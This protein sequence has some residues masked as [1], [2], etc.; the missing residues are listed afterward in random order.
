MTKTITTAKVSGTYILII[1]LATVFSWLLHEF[2][3][4]LTGTLL[5]NTMAMTFNTGYPVSGNY[6]ASSHENIV[7]IAGPLV[8]LLQA[9]VVFLIMKYR[10]A[11][12]LYPFLFVCFYMRLLAAVLSILNPNDEARVSMDLGL[13]KFTLHIIMVAVL[14]LLVYFTASR[15]RF[16]KKYNAATLG[17]I[18]LFSSTIVLSDQALHLRLL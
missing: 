2:A 8:T 16:S 6:L 13:G 3:H 9:V 15:Y 10:N 4:W 14:F 11:A 1:L 18:V 17:F 7:S 12:R 5:G